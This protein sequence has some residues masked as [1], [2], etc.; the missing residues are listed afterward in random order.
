M[1]EKTG[2]YRT[3]HVR[4]R[5]AMEGGKKQLCWTARNANRCGITI[6]AKPFFD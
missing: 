4:G 6:E 2:D 5:N 3:A 1:V